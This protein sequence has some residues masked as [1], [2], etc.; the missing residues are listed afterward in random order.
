MRKF[1]KI[2]A[3]LFFM[4]GV[5]YGHNPISSV[6][7]TD[8]KLTTVRPEGAHDHLLSVTLGLASNFSEP[9]SS[10]SNPYGNYFRNGI[11][12]AAQNRSKDL[13]KAG[14][15]L[16]FEEF[17]YGT[18]QLRVLEA[19]KN[20]EK[21]AVLAVIGYNFSSH[22]LMAA[23]LH[24][25]AKFPMITPSATANRL[26]KMGAFVHQG[27]FD[28]D[29]MGNT[30]ARVAREKLKA[31]KAAI[32]V[33]ADCAYCQ[34]LARSF[35]D[36]FTTSGGKVVVRSEI[37]ETDRDFTSSIYLLK[38]NEVDIILVPNQEL[39]SARV[40]SAVLKAGISKPFLGGDGWG[41]VGEEFFSVLGGQKLEGYSVS[42]WHP[43]MKDKISTQFYR[44]FTSK[45]KNPPNDTA[46]LA[47]DTTMLTIEALL[48]MKKKI[49][50]QWVKL[51]KEQKRLEME[52]ALS[53]IK[54]FQGVTGQYFS[55]EKSAPEKSLVL[56]KAKT[57]GFEVLEQIHPHHE[58][59]S[60]TGRR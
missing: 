36:R 16:S 14:L 39:N 41:N 6:D 60:Q 58:S 32:I 17:D 24:Q 1:F 30:L 9:S 51:G 18:N 20:A 33:A 3:A 22:A 35:E 49:A 11:E 23:P 10:S 50:D 44:Q 47:Y 45:F 54:T 59:E 15:H 43:K 34:D 53:G 2:Y 40:I 21:S 37:L 4:V 42:H 13:A 25:N 27:C 52:K 55:Q 19:A 12:L 46:V 48:I 31:Q 29:F 57:Q 38:K 8:V 5:C 7:Q 28:N 56:L 26:G